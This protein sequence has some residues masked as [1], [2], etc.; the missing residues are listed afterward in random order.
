MEAKCGNLPEL[1][2]L[3]YSR[4][5]ANV[6]MSQLTKGYSIATRAVPPPAQPCVTKQCRP[7]QQFA[8]AQAWLNPFYTIKGPKR[9]LNIDF[10]SLFS[11]LLLLE[12]KEIRDHV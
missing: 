5:A 2:I 9:L 11:T 1:G 12:P 10:D 4:A 8:Q 6:A 3:T 7:P